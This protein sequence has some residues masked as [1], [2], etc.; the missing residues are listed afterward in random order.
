MAAVT[1]TVVEAV[2]ERDSDEFSHHDLTPA[3]ET[4][5]TL[6]LQSSYSLNLCHLEEIIVVL[7]FG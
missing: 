7:K 6:V 2:R 4:G 3:L 1:K 5:T